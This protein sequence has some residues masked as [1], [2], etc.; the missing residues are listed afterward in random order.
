MKLSIPILLLALAAPLM[1]GDSPHRH[2]SRTV[3]FTGYFN[4]YDTN[5]DGVISWEEFQGTVG[6]SDI[7][8]LTEWRFLYMADFIKTAS[9][10]STAKIPEG[11]FLDTY[12]RY[13][14]G[15]R[16]PKP[17]KIQRF[18]LADDNDDGFLS[19]SEYRS[20]RKTAA[21]TDGSIGKSFDKIDKNRDGKISPQE[22]GITKV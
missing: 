2:N 22:Y 11:I 21:A 17:T 7:P 3:V 9:I 4:L 5:D 20:T 15:L 16:V 10:R 8:V 13:A 18:N 1:A 12:I 6:A 19:I 14:G